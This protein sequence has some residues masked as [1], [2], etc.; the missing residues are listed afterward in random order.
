MHPRSGFA[1]WTTAVA[2]AGYVFGFVIG[3]LTRL[4]EDAEIE[5]RM[6]WGSGAVTGAPVPTRP[7]PDRLRGHR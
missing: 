7:A 6:P 2:F 3:R 4:G 1:L 5:P